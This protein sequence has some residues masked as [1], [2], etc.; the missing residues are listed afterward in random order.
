MA[1]FLKT[2]RKRN[3]V[4]F[5]FGLLNLAGVLICGVLILLTTQQVLGIN[6]FIKPLKFFLS[7]WIFTWTMGWIMHL[8]NNQR[9]VVAYS[10]MVVIV[11]V[12]EMLIIT[13]QAANG[14]LSHFNITTFLYA[15]LFDVMG[16][17][18]TTLA[19]WTGYIGYLFFRQKHF[20][21]S[22]AYIWGIRLGIILFVL[23]AFEGFMMAARLAHTV[24][25][26][27]G[28]PG[29]PLTNWSTQHGDLRIAHFLGM[30]SLQ[31]LPL[32]GFYIARKSQQ[33][34]VFAVLYAAIA[35]FLLFKAMQGSPLL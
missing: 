29:L 19:I 16:V 35:S 5:F 10:W 26:S 33:V 30:H 34:I 18:I 1:Y 11:F 17:A 14:R 31:L 3:P 28:G 13:W 12:I 9:K 25:A 27:D 23:F 24:G 22:D 21:A 7:I 2:L 8:L 20:N 4:L 15:R 6:A 32:F